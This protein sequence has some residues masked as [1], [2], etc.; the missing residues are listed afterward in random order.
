MS[1]FA[2]F[3][4]GDAVVLSTAIISVM[5]G[6]VVAVLKLVP[7]R[8]AVSAS[9]SSPIEKRVSHVEKLLQQVEVEQAKAIER[10]KYIKET[11][12][13]VVRSLDDLDKK[14]DKMLSK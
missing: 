10:G 1:L 7:A 3:T 5:G 2:S 12:D 6:I 14:I 11:L 4:V 13:R 9:S 8:S